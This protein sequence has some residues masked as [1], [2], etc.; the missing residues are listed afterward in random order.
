[1]EI[2]INDV[3]WLRS[4]ERNLILARK[5]ITQSGDNAGRESWE[6]VGYYTSLSG[7]VKGMLDQGVRDSKAKSLMELEQDYRETCTALYG[8]CA[9]IDKYKDLLLAGGD[10]D[11]QDDPDNGREWQW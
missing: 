10:N 8:L 6:H 7:L 4:D 1:M 3:Y 9:E 5:R 2:Q 11:G